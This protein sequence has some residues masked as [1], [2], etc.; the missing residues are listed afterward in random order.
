M[1]T[2]EA[3]RVLTEW[4]TDHD[5]A[6]TAAAEADTAPELSDE[7]ISQLRQLLATPLETGSAA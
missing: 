1:N 7:Q 6:A 4:S 3:R 2:A 5:L